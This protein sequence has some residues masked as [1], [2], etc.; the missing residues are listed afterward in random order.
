MSGV[1][2]YLGVTRSGKT[3]LAKSHLAGDVAA[4]GRP[5][6]VVNSQAVGNFS[7]VPHVFT[8]REA[9]VSLWSEGRSVAFVPRSEEDFDLL[10]RA[11]RAAGR[12]N[13]L[14]DES[15]YWASSRYISPA[16]SQLL[17]TH[18]HSDVIVR[19]TTQHVADV[20]QEALQTV[21]ALY[22]FRCSA[23]RALDRLRTEFGL[24]SSAVSALPQGGFIEHRLGF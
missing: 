4:N 7:D 17:R 23:P 20:P 16:F 8:V 9:V 5:A 11:V 1:Y 21:T 13:V 3:T 10:M 6:L 18:Q 15:F 14:I 2:W 19:A 24:D 22:V 12:V